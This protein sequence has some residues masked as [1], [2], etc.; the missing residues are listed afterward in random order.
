M[1][2]IYEV[3]MV[4]YRYEGKYKEAIEAY[5]PYFLLDP[6]DEDALKNLAL[7][8]DELRDPSLR[9]IPKGV[10]CM[11]GRSMIK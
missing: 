3:L 11:G 1:S 10:K 5:M 6:N 4:S 8:R 2:A 9:K 7:L